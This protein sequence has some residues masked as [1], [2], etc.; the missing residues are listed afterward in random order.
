M[1]VVL[2]HI[3]Y[4]YLPFVSV[5]LIRIGCHTDWHTDYILHC[6]EILACPHVRHIGRANC[7]C[8]RGVSLHIC[9]FVRY[10]RPS[11]WIN[12][13][14]MPRARVLEL[15]LRLSALWFGTYCSRVDLHLRGLPKCFPRST[16]GIDVRYAGELGRQHLA[17]PR[18]D[19]HRG[20]AQ[21]R[22]D[23]GAPRSSRPGF[24]LWYRPQAPPPH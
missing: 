15:L 2:F 7:H 9:H 20:A 10:R 5:C 22:P 16:I 13:K 14:S 1:R 12:K 8:G 3:D 18:Q 23:P 11:R 21:V 19:H 4:R 6:E 24:G 17:T